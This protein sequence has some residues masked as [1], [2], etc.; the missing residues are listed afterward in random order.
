MPNLQHLLD[1]INFALCKGNLS[2]P[3]I[4]QIDLSASLLKNRILVP[5]CVLLD[6]GPLSQQV[7]VDTQDQADGS[8]WVAPLPPC[9]LE[10]TAGMISPPFFFFLIR[11]LH[12]LQ[13]HNTL[14]SVTL[15]KIIMK[16]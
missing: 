2:T 1:L 7:V 10:H 4:S 6:G 13:A 11:S 16:V 8:I 15:V 9:L 12:L 5:Q 3:I 14:C